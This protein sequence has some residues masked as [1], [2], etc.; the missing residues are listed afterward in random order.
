RAGIGPA[1]HLT[2]MGIPVIANRPGVG[3]NLL[4]HPAISV[5]TFL[6]R[7]SRLG[8]G[9]RRHTHVGLRYSSEIDGCPSHD[10]YMVA[11]SKS[12]WHPVGKQIGSL[13]TWVNKTYSAGEV[14]LLSASHEEEPDVRF[15]L[16]SDQRD[17]DRLVRGM[18][19]MMD[20]CD[21]ESLRDHILDRFPSSYSERIRDLGKVS[22]KN[23]LSTSVL[24]LALDGPGE[25]RKAMIRHVV[26]EGASLSDLRE[27]NVLLNDFVRNKVHGV[28]H[29]AGTCRMGASSDDFAVTDPSGKVF[30]V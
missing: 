9:L 4:E 14:L 8:E 23:L 13:V 10:M 11:L 6:R 2:E 15:R 18:R 29:A 7:R 26:T 17:L 30:G 25:L 16:L 1:G 21:Q 12:G 27:S 24:A 19:K 20:L 22:T 3:R 28:W 5:S